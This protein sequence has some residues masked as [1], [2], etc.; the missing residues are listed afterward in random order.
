MWA[1]GMPGPPSTAGGR[2]SPGG[3]GAPHWGGMA[4]GGMA[5]GGMAWGGMAPGPMPLGGGGPWKAGRRGE[6]ARRGEPP[7]R[8]ELARDDP[9]EPAA[10][11]AISAGGTAPCA[12]PVRSIGGVERGVE[13]PLRSIACCECGGC[14]RCGRCGRLQAGGR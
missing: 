4:W 13:P 8:G 11:A 9:W 7:S 6:G 2:G 14:G 12:N 1:G 3:G 10:A 5:W